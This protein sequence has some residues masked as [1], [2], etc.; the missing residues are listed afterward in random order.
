MEVRSKVPHFFQRTKSNHNL[1]SIFNNKKFGQKYHIFFKERNQITT[2]L[3]V[4]QQV[5]MV[6][7]TTFFSKNEIK[8]QQKRGVAAPN[9][10]SKVPHF[11]QRTKS[12]HNISATTQS[13][14]WGQKYHIF[15]KERNQITTY[16][17]FISDYRRVKSTTFFSKNEIKSQRCRSTS[18]AT[19]RSKV[20][21]FFQR[22][23]SN[24]N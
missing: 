19:Q 7:S 17:L 13:N 16:L 23:K 10:R 5:N 1:C 8:S 18:P 9:Q 11:F 15:F 3:Y 24:H 6:K 22:T 20:P 4:P 14:S 12:N 21:H 2:R